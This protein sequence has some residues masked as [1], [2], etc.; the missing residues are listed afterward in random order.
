MSC[1]VLKIVFVYVCF[2]LFTKKLVIM[3]NLGRLIMLV[4]LNTGS[5]H[6]L[7]GCKPSETLSHLPR[8]NALRKYTSGE[9]PAAVDLRVFM[10]PVEDQEDMNSW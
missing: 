4:N 9:L 1:A 8:F 6:P 3:A 2:R 7:N 10:T 5:R